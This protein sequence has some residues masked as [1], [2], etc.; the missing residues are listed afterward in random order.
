LRA[1]GKI[2]PQDFIGTRTRFQRLRDAKLFTGWIED[3]FGTKVVIS[4]NTNFAVQVGDEFRFEGF[5]HHIS[6]V[7]TAVLDS[8]GQLSL[9]DA[10]RVTTI[11]GTNARIV[12]A[13]RVS[14]HLTL[15]G[16]VRFSASHENLRMRTSDL[17]AVVADSVGE[18]EM[19][20]VDVS[21][22]GLGLISGTPLKAK[23]YVKIRIET[24]LGPVDATGNVRYCRLDRDRDGMYRVGLQFMDMD[25]VN[26]PRWERYLEKA[27]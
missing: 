8:V 21:Q 13:K 23:D 15:V 12:E 26:R 16:P 27:A 14:F 1:L 6:V 22:G 18:H 19:I 24:R 25:R 2:S 4:S 10:G 17:F 20:V 11:E 7:F 9:V 3:F 5:G